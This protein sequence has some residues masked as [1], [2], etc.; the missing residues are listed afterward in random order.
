M[1][2]SARVEPLLSHRQ[3]TSVTMMMVQ[4]GGCARVI[5]HGMAVYLSAL[6][7]QEEKMVNASLHACTL[8]VRN[9][10]LGMHIVHA[11]LEFLSLVSFK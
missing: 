11:V 4:Q 7:T 5:G 1:V 2:W 10:F 9:Q 3:S 8:L 6:Q